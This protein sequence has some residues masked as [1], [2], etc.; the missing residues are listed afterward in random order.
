[1]WSHPLNGSGLGGIAAT[2]ST[3]IFGDRD[4]SDQQDVFQCLDAKSGEPLW[5]LQYAAPGALDYGN[6]PRGTPLIADGRV[7]LQGAMGHL[8]C[9]RLVDG[10]ILWK[11]NLR[12]D[13]GA[14]D[15]LVWGTCGSP[16]LADGKLIVNPGAAEAS[17]VALDPVT[18]K[19]LWAAPGGPAAYGSL[20]AVELG[21]VPQVVGHDA[22]SLGGWRLSSG[23]R[24][25][26]L[27]PDLAD[28]FN[29][30]M[31]VVDGDALIVSSENNG[32]RRY[33]FGEDGRIVSR[34][35][36]V[37]ENVAPDTASPVVSGGVLVSLFDQLY[38]LDTAT[39]VQ[40][41]VFADEAISTYGSLIASDDRLLVAGASGELL[42]FDLTGGELQ[43]LS[44]L[45]LFHEPGG[46]NYAHPALVGSRLYIRGERALQ[47]VDL[48][49][50]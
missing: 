45:T 14:T 13:F 38:A 50:R 19:V 8:H 41:G 43:L 12:T 25:W 32:T 21:G 4:L 47:C 46:E 26:K 9:V 23:E 24:L 7:Y 30:P 18:G 6:T 31:P 20:M 33:T 3:V 40:R 5:S 35:V 37:A 1:M 39:L 15:E 36:A 44:R 49:T 16:L 34:P 27:T 2:S 11:R 17:I 29:V 42:L 10:E 22:E 28:D 48:A